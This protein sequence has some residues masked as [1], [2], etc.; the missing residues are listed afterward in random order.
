MESLDN[1]KNMELLY[2]GSENKFSA[3]AFHA[4][5]GDVENTLTLIRT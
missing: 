5:C 3:A 1:P 4:K 2:R